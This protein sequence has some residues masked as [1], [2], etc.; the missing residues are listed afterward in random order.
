MGSEKEAVL[1]LLRFYSEVLYPMPGLRPG[2]DPLAAAYKTGEH[3]V[4]GNLISVLS[5]HDT[6]S[7][8]LA[9]VIGQF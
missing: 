9:T 7:E 1:E 2:G 6:I 4:L 5:E 8:A 3:D